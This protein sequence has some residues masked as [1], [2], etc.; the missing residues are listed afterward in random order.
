MK[1]PRCIVSRRRIFLVK[2]FGLG[3]VRLTVRESAVG[4]AENK[5]IYRRY[6]AALRRP[7][8]LPEVLAR[9]FVAN[10]MAPGSGTKEFVNYRRAVM[11]SFPDQSGEIL[12]RRRRSRGG[13]Q[14]D[15][16]NPQRRVPR[17]AAVFSRKA[18]SCQHDL[19]SLLSGSPS[20]G[21]LC[22]PSNRVYYFKLFYED[23][24]IARV[25]PH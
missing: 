19:S 3:A 24:H 9:D 13:A 7:D 6:Q 14:P 12:G 20:S 25:Q 11:A 4:L 8:M 23:G 16:S 17:P 22:E 18:S 21:L 10:D 15:R 1:K 2:R 5:E